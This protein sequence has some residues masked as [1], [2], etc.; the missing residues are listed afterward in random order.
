MGKNCLCWI[1]ITS[2][3]SCEMRHKSAKKWKIN[4]FSANIHCV[5]LEL[6]W[7]VVMAE[8]MFL[9]SSGC[10]FDIYLNKWIAK[11]PISQ[12]K[13]NKEWNCFAYECLGKSYIFLHFHFFLFEKEKWDGGKQNQSRMKFNI[14]VPHIY[15][16]M[17]R[18]VTWKS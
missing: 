14:R 2:S 18:K 5:R 6:K 12:I 1:I 4:E 16:E 9:K 10:C 13:S 15:K 8:R 17:A 3:W 7:V 11:I